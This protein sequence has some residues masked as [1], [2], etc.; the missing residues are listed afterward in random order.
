[1]MCVVIC[2]IVRVAIGV[3]IR[4]TMYV[5][6][7][8]IRCGDLFH[9]SYAVL[10]Y[11]ALFVL[12]FVLLLGERCMLCV[13]RLGVVICCIVHVPCCV[14]FCVW[15]FVS[16]FMCRVVLHCSSL[17]LSPMWFSQDGSILSLQ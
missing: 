15:R 11:V 7:V 12:R 4:Y 5:V 16:L 14:A 6:C 2:C 3:E 8:A 9:C 1:M 10:C 13:W 17:L